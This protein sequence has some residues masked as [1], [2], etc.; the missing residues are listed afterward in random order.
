MHKSEEIKQIIDGLKT[1]RYGDF[2]GLDSICHA[3]QE[4]FSCR[5][6]LGQK[7]LDELRSISFSPMV[8]G[9]GEELRISTWQDGKE[10]LCRLFIKAGEEVQFMD[11]FP[12]GEESQIN[13]TPGKALI[14][15]GPDPAFN[16]EIAGVLDGLPDVF[17]LPS[18]LDRNM[19]PHA[20]LA[21][22]FVA[23]VCMEDE[24]RDRPG[25]RVQIKLPKD[26]LLQR[27]FEFG[28]L[29]GVLGQSRV[30]AIDR[31]VNPPYCCNP[32]NYISIDGDGKWQARVRQITGINNGIPGEAD[33]ETD[34]LLREG[35]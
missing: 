10:R 19:E 11:L 22:V 25:Y 29:T 31:K 30:F 35:G 34:P 12:A 23:F 6:E 5:P 17:M 24:I 32:S 8:I 14:L 4:L 7:F 27:M 2:S 16:E 28:Y 15:T 26:H 20:P 33:C 3:A 1:L 21:E 9:A 18:L 13:K